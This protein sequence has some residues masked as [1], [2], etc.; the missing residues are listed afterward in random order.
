VSDETITAF[1]DPEPDLGIAGLVD[2]AE[3]GRGGF[4]IVY[5][6]REPKLNRDVAVKV[7]AGT[8]DATGSAR[9]EREAFAMG[10]LADHPNIVQVLRT[11][12]DR[13]GRPYLVMPF[14]ASGSL[15]DGQV[16]PWPEVV[17]FAVRLCGAL[18][19]AH[20][21]TVLHRDIKPANVLLSDYGEPLLAD[22]G[23]ARITGGFQ[24]S[25][26]G[27][28]ASLAYAAPEILEG[29][30]ASAS[31][32]IYSLG[33]TLFCLL[34]G[35]PPIVPEPG[36]VVAATVA[37]VGRE[38]VPD[39]R[40]TGVPTPLCD[41]L[42][43]ALAKEPG[44]RPRSA[45]AFGRELQDIQR[46]S[47]Q[48]V[49]DLPLTVEAGTAT[50]DGVEATAAELPTRR[51]VAPTDEVRSTGGGSGPGE[52]N[53]GGT[54]ARRRALSIGAA[55]VVAALVGV[56][57]V[58][59]R[60][61]DDTSGSSA[62]PSTTDVT[63]SFALE[64]TSA[65]AALP[66]GGVLVADAAG[67]RVLRINPDGRA[68]TVTGTGVPGAPRTGAA[69][70]DT[71]VSFPSAV[72]VG[73]EGVV[74]V[75]TEGAVVRIG[76]DGTVS[77]VSDVPAGLKGIRGLAA[78][79]DDLW[80]AGLQ[81]VHRLRDGRFER[82][83]DLPGGFEHIEALAVHPDGGVVVTDSGR[84]QVVRVTDGGSAVIGGVE[85][86]E[87]VPVG[88]GA[89]ATETALTPVGV[90]VDEDGAVFVSEGGS[91][92]VRR[93]DPDGTVRTVAGSPDGYTAGDSGDGGPAEL[94]SFRLGTG[95]LAVLADGR[96]LIADAGNHRLRV[97]EDDG[98]VEAWP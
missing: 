95:P 31:S 71:Q 28:T 74:W 90:A 88:D 13:R 61:A 68:G 44:A 76:V 52:S 67:H 57:L 53:D 97:I 63:A 55:V 9:F 45:E 11:G 83:D 43:R 37:R 5:R 30:A 19:T 21:R 94:A 4:G 29:S 56:L 54:R 64:K 7:L 33:A 18:E 48:T 15:A 59:L 85:D 77:T 93:I 78:D 87:G 89:P 36:A 22:F 62:A 98:T 12:I 46:V 66:D 40:P 25:S 14:L 10:T 80:V 20:R 1:H 32:D 70:V 50:P 72:A 86:V 24:T 47:G 26:A 84:S 35:L 34:S 92:R 81:S 17:R 2:A 41:L 96:L 60:P 38:P 49:T 3:I 73:E 69:A 16:R 79:G 42:E 65:L 58:V 8:L 6:A 91:N 75:G 23:I 27:L 51:A 39:L 82:I